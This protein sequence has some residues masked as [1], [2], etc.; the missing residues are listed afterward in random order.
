MVGL[1][2]HLKWLLKWF[3][4]TKNFFWSKAFFKY[5]VPPIYTV[6]INQKNELSVP[7]SNLIIP[8]TAGIKCLLEAFQDLHALALSGASLIVST[9]WDQIEINGVC[10]NVYNTQSIRLLSE[11]FIHG[12]YEV[13]LL[14]NSVV[15]DVG[16]NVG[17]STLF[18]AKTLGCPVYGYEPFKE[19]FDR[20][21]ANIRLNSNISDKIYPFQYAVGWESRKE[22]FV[23][24]PDSP[25]DCGIIPIPELYQQSRAIYKEM[26]EII[27]IA[28]VI[29]V[30]RKKNPHSNIILKLDCEG[31]E[32]EI[33][34]CLI[35]TGLISSIKVILMEWHRRGNLGDP[36]IVQDH[37]KNNGFITFG[38]PYRRS[39]IGMLYAVN[40]IY[41]H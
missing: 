32:Y 15:I 29:A 7:N 30:I 37:L 12:A 26:V 35:E 6:Y 23:F 10:F 2:R 20:A 16:M 41:K 18:F 24:C 28:E 14:D 27:S 33:I 38:N 22:E 21:F 1:L 3:Y 39:E 40:S 13:S 31:M 8:K 5:R 36:L 25:G 34:N 11:V 17:I 19:T 9:P 4:L